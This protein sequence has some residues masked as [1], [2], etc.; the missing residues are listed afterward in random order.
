MQPA[1]HARQA[2]CSTP[3]PVKLKTAFGLFENH[4]YYIMTGVNRPYLLTGVYTVESSRD[5]S[6]N[7]L[8]YGF[9]LL[10]HFIILNLVG[11]VSKINFALLFADKL[12][13]QPFE[14]NLNHML[15]PLPADP[16]IG[17]W[18]RSAA[19]VHEAMLCP[20]CSKLMCL[21]QGFINKVSAPSASLFLVTYFSYN[22][23][24][25]SLRTNC[26]AFLSKIWKISFKLNPLFARLQKNGN[27]DNR[28]R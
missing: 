25:T 21:Y 1:R 2:G 27:Y 5:F 7:S 19:V 13:F 3:A 11:R 14:V 18:Y 15:C 8:A 20:L 24:T 6:W 17:Q 22:W 28:Y 23:N 12:F 16:F 4:I 10:Y 9:I 26:F